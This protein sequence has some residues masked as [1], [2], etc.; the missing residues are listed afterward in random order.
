MKSTLW[1][2]VGAVL[3]AATGVIPQ[4]VMGIINYMFTRE[5][6]LFTLII[7]GLIIYGATIGKKQVAK[8]DAWARGKFSKGD[9]TA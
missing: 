8:M 3:F 1:F 6:D 9:D 4:V 7:V 5:V 2:R